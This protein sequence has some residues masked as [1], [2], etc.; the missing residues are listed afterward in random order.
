MRRV[1]WAAGLVIAIAA[2]RPG[3]AEPPGG[4]PPAAVQKGGIAADTAV[5]DMTGEGT[6][7]GQ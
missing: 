6:R 4:E 7:A 3:E 2:C 1:W 5:Q